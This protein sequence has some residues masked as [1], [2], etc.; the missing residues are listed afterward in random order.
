MTHGLIKKLNPCTKTNLN[1]ELLCSVCICSDVNPSTDL[2]EVLYPLFSQISST[3]CP[4]RV[5][6]SPTVWLTYGSC[7][8]KPHFQRWWPSRHGG[9]SRSHQTVFLYF[10]K[11][12]QHPNFFF[13]FFFFLNPYF[14]L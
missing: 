5:T 10:F 3:Q 13:F 2:S 9:L 6:Y 7:H 4:S 8:R 1:E 11:Q 12:L 14:T